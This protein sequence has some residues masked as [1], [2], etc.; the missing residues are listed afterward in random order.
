MKLTKLTEEHICALP[1]QVIA[2]WQSN[3]FVAKSSAEWLKDTE[4]LLALFATA[5]LA[6]RRDRSLLARLLPFAEHAPYCKCLWSIEP[7]CTCG[8]EGLLEEVREVLD[9]QD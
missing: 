9:E 3:Q 4:W 5:L 8:L 2:Y 7:V 6:L 1:M